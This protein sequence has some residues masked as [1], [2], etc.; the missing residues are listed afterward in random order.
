MSLLSDIA[1]FSHLLN[2]LRLTSRGKRGTFGYQK[3]LVNQAEQLLAIQKK[4]LNGTFRWGKYRQFY[5][6]DPKKRLVSSASFQ[7]RIMHT[8]IHQVIEPYFDK[9]MTESVYACRKGRGNQRAVLYLLEAL[10]KGG[11]DRFV[12]KL[13]IKG[14]FASV[15]QRLLWDLVK[16][17]LPDPSIDWLLK[18]LISSYHSGHPNGGIPIGNLTSQL[19]AN[20]FFLSQQMLS[21]IKI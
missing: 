3:V 1:D 7:D 17:A 4:L 20:F 21:L 15:H 19:F 5:V 18:S 13:D 10:K 8:A 2:S 12:I 14:Y 11:P 16:E 9:K 6:A